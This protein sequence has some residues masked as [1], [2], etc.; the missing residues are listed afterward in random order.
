M[1]PFKTDKGIGATPKE[2]NSIKTQSEV[3]KP[4]DGDGK[5]T[6]HKENGENFTPIGAKRSLQGP[7]NKKPMSPSPN[8][9]DKTHLTT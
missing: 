9:V 2:G 6:L 8:G 1:K 3:Y 4:T 7:D 5:I